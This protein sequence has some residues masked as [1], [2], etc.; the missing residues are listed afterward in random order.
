VAEEF[1]EVA[2]AR[3]AVAVRYS[4]NAGA[5]RQIYTRVEWAAFPDGVKSASSTI[6]VAAEPL[7]A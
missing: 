3:A 7:V 4:E 5:D 2:F 1:V 6:E